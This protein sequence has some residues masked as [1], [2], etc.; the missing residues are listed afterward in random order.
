MKVD[1]SV[2][3]QFSNNLRQCRT[4]K[5]VSWL[6]LSTLNNLRNTFICDKLDP[7]TVWPNVR[8][9]AAPNFS[10]I[11]PKIST[12]VFCFRG[13]AFIIAAKLT[14]YLG[15][16]CKKSCHQQG[17]SKIAQPGHTGPEIQRVLFYNCSSTASQWVAIAPR[18]ERLPISIIRQLA[19]EVVTTLR[20]GL[21]RLSQFIPVWPRPR[22]VKNKNKN[23]IAIPRSAQP[24]Y[25]DNN[26]PDRNRLL[27]KLKIN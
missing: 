8:I 26:W 23:T 5:N 18:G 14:K 25:A 22:S 10:Q 13:K 16:F 6:P 21:C 7:Q 2:K 4:Y 11:C 27:D 24:S 17:L 9:K 1:E 20:S 15:Y 12:P 3:E 19:V